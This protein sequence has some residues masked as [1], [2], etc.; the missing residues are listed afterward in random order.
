MV[1]NADGNIY[2]RWLGDHVKKYYRLNYS[3]GLCHCQSSG[4]NTGLVSKG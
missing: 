1:T 3:L 4:R 2:P